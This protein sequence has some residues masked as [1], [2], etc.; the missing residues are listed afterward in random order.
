LIA[1]LAIPHADRLWGLDM[2]LTC[3]GNRP[4]PDNLSEAI[5][6]ILDREIAVG[7]TTG[8]FEDAVSPYE[9]ARRLA[10]MLALASIVGSTPCLGIIFAALLV[11]NGERS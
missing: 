8:S 3:P 11:C 9:D 7:S 2:W 1:D 4:V 6:R 5:Q 10:E